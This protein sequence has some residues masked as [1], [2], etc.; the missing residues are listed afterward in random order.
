MIYFIECDATGKIWHIQQNPMATIV[1][2]VNIATFKEVTLLDPVGITVA[3]Y[4]T[5]MTGGLNNF[6]YDAATNTVVPKPAA[7]APAST[8]TNASQTS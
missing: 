2:L 8:P 5:I 6:T 1:P 4:N 3:Q 7:P